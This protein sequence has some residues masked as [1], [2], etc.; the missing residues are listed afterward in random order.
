MSG[1][2]GPRVNRR[3]DPTGSTYGGIY[4]NG[5]VA[6]N[7]FEC[8]CLHCGLIHNRTRRNLVALRSKANK[9]N[10]P[11]SCGCRHS[12]PKYSGPEEYVYNR[13]IQRIKS[14]AK[15]RSIEWSLTEKEAI[16]LMNMPCFYCATKDGLQVTLDKQRASWGDV[17]ESFPMNG[18]DRFDNNIGYTKENSIPCCTNCNKSKLDRSFSDFYGW[19]KRTYEHM[20]KS[21][22]KYLEVA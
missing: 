6:E 5:T 19:V 14:G 2:P 3:I 16:E 11:L 17:I 13:R 21:V 12:I 15:K 1:K 7:D 22:F 20:N 10:L 18:I 4:V 8:V 9:T